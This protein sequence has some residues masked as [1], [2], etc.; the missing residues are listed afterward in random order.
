MNQKGAVPVLILIAVIGI[1][2]FL[3]VSYISPL[4]NQL[5]SSIFPKDESSAATGYPAGFSEI[6]VA[7]GLSSPTNMEF[8]PDGRLFIN[9]RGGRVKIF[10]NG[11][12][13]PTPFLDI[14]TKL[15]RH[16]QPT[17]IL[18]TFIFIMQ[19]PQLLKTG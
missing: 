16:L 7:T 13:L 14:S 12:L 6:R 17:Q 10:K 3:G 11:A 1:V 4:R 8:A 9:E 5:L 18:N 2:G 15:T 19:T